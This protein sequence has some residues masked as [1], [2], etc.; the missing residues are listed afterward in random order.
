M[1]ANH[2]G[3]ERG[4][5]IYSSFNDNPVSGTVSCGSARVCYIGALVRE[6]ATGRYWLSAS[7]PQ[8]SVNK[9]TTWSEAM[10]QFVDRHG[11]NTL[12]QY[13]TPGPRDRACFGSINILSGWATAANTGDP[14]PQSCIMLPTTTTKCTASAVSPTLDHANIPANNWNGH[15]VRTN[16]IVTCNAKTTVRIDNPRGNGPVALGTTMNTTLRVNGHNLGATQIL[17]NMANTVELSSTIG[18][19]SAIPGSFATNLVLRI[20][21][22]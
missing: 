18:G 3:G 1:Y 8:I 17:E 14:T 15:T 22:P 4:G 19:T 21:Y 2:I 6:K 13:S 5:R 20:N 16:V 11:K 12:T 9:G 7:N 10:R